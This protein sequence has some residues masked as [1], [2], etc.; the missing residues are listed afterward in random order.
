[1]SFEALAAVTDVDPPSTG[2]LVL[3]FLLADAADDQAICYPSQDTLSGK[4][5]MSVRAVRDNLAALVRAGLI[6]VERRTRKDGTRTSNQI[7]LLFYMP[8]KVTA[9]V[10][11]RAKKPAQPAAESAGGEIEAKALAAKDFESADQR[12]ILPVDQRQNSTSLPAMVAGP[13]TF[14]PVREPIRSLRSLSARVGEIDWFELSLA[15]YPEAGRKVT[16]LPAARAA[17]A[18]AAAEAG[19]GERLHACV[20]AYA[21]DPDLKR[22]DFGAPSFQ[23]WLSGGRWRPYLGQGGESAMAVRPVF[24]GPPELRQAV[25]ATWGEGFALAY[26][27]PCA[28]EPANRWLVPRTSIARARLAAAAHLLA[29]HGV[30]LANQLQ[31]AFTAS[32][33]RP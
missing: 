1:M 26:L 30:T 4:A 28:F 18:Q 12:Q 7:R 11:K 16:D 3:L 5:K 33:V 23:R 25:A 32:E 31:P 10:G 20:L 9:Y 21:A 13:T 22:R 19:G 27:D 14:E 29:A 24:A 2:A 15:V 17:W 8:R 6:E